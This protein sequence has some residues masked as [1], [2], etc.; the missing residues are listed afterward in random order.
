[1]IVDICSTADFHIGLQISTMAKE[2]RTEEMRDPTRS[3]WQLSILP[4]PILRL[5]VVCLRD[6]NA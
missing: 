6:V 2:M 4:F 5:S 3:E 1:M